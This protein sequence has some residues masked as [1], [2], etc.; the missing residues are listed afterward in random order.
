L[1]ALL[2]SLKTFLPL[3]EKYKP[4]VLLG[5]TGSVASLKT[6]ELARKLSEF[7]EVLVVATKSALHFFNKEELEKTNIIL[8]DEDEYTAWTKRGD[9]VVHIELR[10]WA[11]LII[12]APLSANTLGKLAN[13]LC[14]NLP[15]CIARAWDFK[16]GRPF[17]VAP[18]MNT[19]MLDHPFTE[20][21]LST[22]KE[23]GIIVIDTVEK[24]LQCNEFGKGAMAEVS[25]IVE[26]V[27]GI[28]DS[29]PNCRP[30]WRTSRLCTGDPIPPKIVELS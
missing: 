7:A 3:E 20:R 12:I 24:I 10:R 30:S 15:T 28:A 11:D 6:P 21:Q 22:L 13:G 14:D 17:L 19:M 25:T 1:S 5:V 23:V 9:P 4:H 18:S 26:C 27:R 29:W 8:V 16:G 2:S